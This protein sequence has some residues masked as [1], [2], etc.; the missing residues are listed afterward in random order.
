[1][2]EPERAPEN[3]HTDNGVVAEAVPSGSV[4]ILT[5]PGRT[6]AASA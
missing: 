6:E 5:L 3:N 4:L 1:M 2:A